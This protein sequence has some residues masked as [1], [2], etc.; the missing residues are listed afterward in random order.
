[1][2][3]TSH[4]RTESYVDAA[5]GCN[6]PLNELLHEADDLFG[7]DRPIGCIVS[8]GTG[9]KPLP[10]DLG[11]PSGVFGTI[12]WA[13]GVIKVL[14]ELAVDTEKDSYEVQ[15]R[16]RRFAG[17]IFR[18]NVEGGAEN[19]SLSSYEMLPELR[20]RTYAY[21]NQPYITDDI[22]D[23]SDRLVGNKMGPGLTIGHVCTFF[24][25]SSFHLYGC[26]ILIFLVTS[27]LS[28]QG[29]DCHRQ[30]KCQPRRL[31]KSLLCRARRHLGFSS[32]I[33]YPS[34]PGIRKAS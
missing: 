16:F 27:R 30:S 23:V 20:K 1:M 21:L 13:I 4:D 12:K 3:I 18:F 34:C 19:I 33:L 11:R 31:C 28:R 17:T 2:D 5:L 10:S 24:L 14:K 7:K 9:S 8:L 15:E 6:N 22:K 25:I 26:G 29:S 32:S